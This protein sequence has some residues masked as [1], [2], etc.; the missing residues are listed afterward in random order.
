M[1]ERVE[2]GPPQYRAGRRDQEDRPLPDRP[3]QVKLHTKGGL[4]GPL[5]IV[6]DR[7]HGRGGTQPIDNIEDLFRHRGQSVLRGEQLR[8][9]AV[10]YACHLR[11]LRVGRPLRI[12][13]ASNRICTETRAAARAR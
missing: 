6:E 13:S 9:V 7:D 2:F 5:C 3:G 4:V 1:L 12:S 10:E 8:G 11:P